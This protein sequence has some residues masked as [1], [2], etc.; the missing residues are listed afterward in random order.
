MPT[1]G[2][3]DVYRNDNKSSGTMFQVSTVISIVRKKE[4]SLVK[5]LKFNI[6]FT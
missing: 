5:N 1:F 6:K 3:L 2:I 4:K